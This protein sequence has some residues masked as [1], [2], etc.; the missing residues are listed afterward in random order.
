MVGCMKTTVEIP[1]SLLAEAKRLAVREG[2]TIRALIEQALRRIVQERATQ[3]TFHLRKASFRGGGLQPG[4]R[5]GSW[6]QIRE[7]IYE[8]RGG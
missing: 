8:G 5:E 1:D 7:L 3:S 6:E 4:I 2:T